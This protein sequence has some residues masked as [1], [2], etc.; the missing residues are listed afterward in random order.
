MASKLCTELEAQQFG[1]G[2][3]AQ[4]QNRCITA[5]EIESYGLLLSPDISYK[6]NQC[7]PRDK[8]YAGQNEFWSGLWIRCSVNLFTRTRYDSIE[9]IEIIDFVRNF[10]YLESVTDG[11]T[12][13][14]N[15]F[16]DFGQGTEILKPDNIGNRFN[17]ISWN[18]F[19]TGDYRINITFVKLRDDGLA[20]EERKTL[21]GI[22]SIHIQ[23]HNAAIMIGIGG[24]VAIPNLTLSKSTHV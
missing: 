15:M 23:Q 5:S 11:I 16:K 6:D 4:Y 17:A 10:T 1:G 3:Q 12:N 14:F 22:P 8:L 9:K 24:T 13:N 2:T 21:N 19:P 7:V 20:I 18:E